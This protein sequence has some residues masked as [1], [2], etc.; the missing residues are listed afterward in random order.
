MD[1]EPTLDTV[2]DEELSLAPHGLSG[3]VRLLG[4]SSLL[5]DI[6]GEMIFPLIPSFLR[7]VLGAGPAALGVIEGVADTTASVVKLW[8]GSLS[9]R[10]GKR[11]VFVVTGYAL[12]AVSRPLIALAT[13]SWQGLLVRSGDRFGKG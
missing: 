10:I 8:S 2:P 3:N 12:A 7:D 11:K 13:M 5:N 9:D 4:I 1:D 6:A